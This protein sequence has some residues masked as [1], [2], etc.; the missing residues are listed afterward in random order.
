MEKFVIL[1]HCE[2][3][4]E[5]ENDI[6]AIKQQHWNYPY[7]AQI[8]WMRNNLKKNDMHLLLYEDGQPVAYLNL[9]NVTVYVDGNQM[10]AVGIGNVCVTK[11][12][13]GY[14]IGRKIVQKANDI[15]KELCMVGVLL[16]KEE[17]LDFYG[18]FGWHELTCGNI[19]IAS[20]DYEKKIMFFNSTIIE[21]NGLSID[22]NF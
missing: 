22:R 20:N 7:D 4:P 10:P 16:C 11:C 18:K 15:I 9:V 1:K 2:L 5:V 8:E 3:R 17:L 6:V 12:K 14:G 19:T 21:V 13:I